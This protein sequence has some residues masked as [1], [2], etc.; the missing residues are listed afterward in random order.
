MTYSEEL[1]LTKQKDFILGEY[2]YM[3]MGKCNGVTV[4]MSVA[5]K[6]DYCVRKA[7]GFEDNANGIVIFCKVNKIKAGES[8]KCDELIMS[9]TPDQPKECK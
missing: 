7:R 2:I 4:C 8:E 9:N 6:I 1:E 3:G 5:Y